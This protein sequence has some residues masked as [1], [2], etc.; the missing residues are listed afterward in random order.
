MTLFPFFQHRREHG[1]FRQLPEK[2]RQIIFYAEDR[3]SWPHYESLIRELTDTRG[4]DI[5]YLTSSAADPI[6]SSD[7]PHIHAFNIGASS[8]RTSVF[9]GVEAKV[10]IMTMPDLDT[11]YIKRSKEAKVHYVYLFHSI[12]STHMIYR[13]RAFDH[14][15]TVFCVGPH[16]VNEI[17]SAERVFALPPKNLHSVS[18]IF[19]GR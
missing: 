1:R 3:S 2:L 17:R 9:L 15:D 14:Y 10:M 8:V 19:L 11:F 16:H 12:V 6:L 13:R 7:N 18:G 4:H 5:C